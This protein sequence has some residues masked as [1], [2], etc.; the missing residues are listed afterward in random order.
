MTNTTTPRSLARR[1]TLQRLALAVEG[2]WAASFRLRIA[3]MLSGAV[4]LSGVLG[5][6]PD[7]VRLVA[8]AALGLALSA[9]LLPLLR[10]VLP[11][12]HDAM[13]RLDTSAG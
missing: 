5:Q 8:S 3:V 6:L 1:I 4:V 2:L 7:G 11:T 10:H 12:R 9:A 13:R